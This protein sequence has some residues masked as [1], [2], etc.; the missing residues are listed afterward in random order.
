VQPGGFG[1]AVAASVASGTRFVW[2][3]SGLSFQ[4]GQVLNF[5]LNGTV[6][7][8][9]GPTLVSNTAFVTALTACTSTRMTT[10]ETDFSLSARSWHQLRQGPDAA[11][12]VECATGGAVQYQIQVTTGWRDGDGPD[13]DRHGGGEL[14]ATPRPS[15]PVRRPVAV[16]VAGSGTRYTW[17][18]TGLAIARRRP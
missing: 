18:A 8:V 7:I 1:P 12:G 16:S 5:T 3:G 14:Q 11:G 9:C 15:R 6:G 4:P 17:A 2:S 10:N 13:R